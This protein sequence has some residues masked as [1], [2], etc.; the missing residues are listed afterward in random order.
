MMTALTQQAIRAVPSPHIILPSPSGAS[1]APSPV[2]ARLQ[3]RIPRERR[4]QLASQASLPLY[5]P[6]PSGSLATQSHPFSSQ[7]LSSAQIERQ[8]VV[9]QL[10]PGWEGYDSLNECGAA[11]NSGQ[12]LVIAFCRAAA[13]LLASSYSIPAT[14]TSPAVDVSF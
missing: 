12:R 4:R 1:P 13:P 6:L 3:L 7:L 10:L 9:W 8:G 14:A 2:K 5:T 11:I